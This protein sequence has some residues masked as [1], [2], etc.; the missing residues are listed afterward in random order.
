MSHITSMRVFTLFYRIVRYWNGNGWIS[1]H[2]VLAFT[3]DVNL[4][5]GECHT[6]T[7]IRNR[8]WFKWWLGTARQQAITRTN[9]DSISPSGVTRPRTS[10]TVCLNYHRDSEIQKSMPV[11]FHEW[12]VFLK[13]HFHMR[14]LFPLFGNPVAQMFYHNAPILNWVAFIRYSVHSCVMPSCFSLCA[15]YGNRFL[16]CTSM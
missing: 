13:G 7:L 5:W 15:Y 10:H 4:L 16:L 6:T 2:T 1:L 3:L 14:K 8:H 12:C 11:I 9:V